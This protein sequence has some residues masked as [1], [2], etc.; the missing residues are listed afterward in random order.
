MS[1]INRLNLGDFCKN[2]NTELELRE[3][4]SHGRDGFVKEGDKNSFFGRCIEVKISG[5]SYNLDKGSLIDFINSKRSEN[6]DQ[7]IK[8]WNIKPSLT[9]SWINWTSDEDVIKELN[10]Y[11]PSSCTANDS[12]SNTFNLSNEAGKLEIDYI[13]EKIEKD[14]R[15]CNKSGLREQFSNANADLPPNKYQT[16]SNPFI[17]RILEVGNGLTEE[18]K[19]DLF[20]KLSQKIM[21]DTSISPDEETK[22]C[23]RLAKIFNSLFNPRGACKN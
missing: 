11:L 20:E 8:K 17:A 19:K 4:D 13:Y 22:R 2:E 16:E 12:N 14:Q 5:I 18:G 1:N 10:K 9:K 7:K 21:N 3:Q 15:G 23:E 6:N